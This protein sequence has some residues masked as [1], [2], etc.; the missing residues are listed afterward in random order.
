MV[1]ISIN[2]GPSVIEDVVEGGRLAAGERPLGVRG[3]VVGHQTRLGRVS[4]SKP[5]EAI[6]ATG[7]HRVV[8]ASGKLLWR[9]RRRQGPVHR[10]AAQG[11][12]LAAR[13]QGRR[14]KVEELNDPSRPD[15][16]RRQIEPYYDR[17][18]LI[19]VTTETVQR[20]PVLGMVLVT[21]ILL[22]FLSN[23]RSGADRGDQH[24]AGAAVRLRG[25]VSAR[26]VGQ[27]A[28]DRRGGLRHHRRFVGHHGREHLPPP[29][30][31]R[32]MPSCR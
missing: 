6:T 9:N 5:R 29:Q 3:V 24:S 32:D 15:A 18:D 17:T 27:P 28:V 16:A 11:R 14:K 22:M 12:G 1:I 4:L 20:E 10:A 30:L 13:P 19:H 8:D 31:R 26:Q 7:I 23:V 25:A 2:N 21:V